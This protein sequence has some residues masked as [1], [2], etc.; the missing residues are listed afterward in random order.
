MIKPYRHFGQWVFDDPAV[1]LHQEPL[2]AG[3][4]T[5]LDKLSEVIP[6]ARSGVLVLFS[7]KPFP[8][9]QI[10]LKQTRKES[11]GTWYYHADTKMEGWLCPALLKYFKKA[12]K[13]LFIQLKP[14]EEQSGQQNGN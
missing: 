10:V 2:I 11:G 6:N 8:E 13:K 9:H 12:P 1:D 3:I 5:M 7:S 14:V 4:D